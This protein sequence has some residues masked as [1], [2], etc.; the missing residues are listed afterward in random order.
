MFWIKYIFHVVLF[1]YVTVWT[2]TC[3]YVCMYIFSF[4]FAICTVIWVVASHH[5]IAVV[6]SQI[7]MWKMN[8]LNQK[9]VSS[10]RTSLMRRRSWVST[11]LKLTIFVWLAAQSTA[12]HLSNHFIIPRNLLALI[13]ISHLVLG[14]FRTIH[15]HLSWCVHASSVLIKCC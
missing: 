8:L 12:G 9:I 10:F 1:L 3:M 5:F 15:S 7:C 6:N 14:T 2:F 11:A 4:I 13:D